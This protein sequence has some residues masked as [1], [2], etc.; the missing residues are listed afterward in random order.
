MKTFLEVVGLV[1][2]VLLLLIPNADDRA[3]VK[4][5]LEL[6]NELDRKFGHKGEDKQNG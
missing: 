3:R 5:Y 1:T 2:F 4:R 6:Q